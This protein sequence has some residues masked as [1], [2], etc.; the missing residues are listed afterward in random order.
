[1]WLPGSV[2]GVGRFRRRHRGTSCAALTGRVRKHVRD[3]VWSAGVDV[4]AEGEDPVVEFGQVEWDVSVEFAADV[5]V[6]VGAAE[7]FGERVA[8][9]SATEFASNGVG[10]AVLQVG[11][12]DAGVVGIGIGLPFGVQVASEPFGVDEEVSGSEACGH[13]SSIP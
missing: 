7:A 3:V 6:P 8:G 11:G 13:G 10:D 9:S 5:V 4:D 12:R 1:M 2:Q